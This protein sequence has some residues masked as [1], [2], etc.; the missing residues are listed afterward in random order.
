MGDFR[1]V[2]DITAGGHTAY[3]FNLCEDNSRPGAREDLEI[4]VAEFI[5]AHPS[6]IHTNHSTLGYFLTWWSHGF[7]RWE[8]G[9]GHGF[10]CSLSCPESHF[11]NLA[12]LEITE[13][14]LPLAPSA[15]IKGV[16]QDIL[17]LKTKWSQSICKSLSFSNPQPRGVSQ[18]FIPSP[19][20]SSGWVV[21][22]RE[23]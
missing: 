3:L 12:G 21:S 2:G 11:V 13:V 19:I 16:A 4:G 14:H 15:G 18:L 17:L 5:A 8:W 20:Q 1:T 22:S 23:S 10:V 9:S 7:L 6:F